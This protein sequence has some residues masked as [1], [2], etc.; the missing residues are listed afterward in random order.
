MRKN[1][2][3]AAMLA[4]S[5]LL[6]GCA[7]LLEREYSTVE[8]HTEQFW[9]S[10]AAGTL[11]AESRQ[12]VVNDLLIL[13]SQHTEKATLRLYNYTDDVNVADML[14][15]A[16][17]EVRRETPM[18]AYAVEYITSS[19][20]AQR[21]YY[22]VELSIGYRRSA[23]QVKAVVNAT[24]AEAVRNLLEGALDAG[25]TELAVRVGYWDES[26]RETVETLISSFTPYSATICRI[27][28]RKPSSTVLFKLMAVSSAVS[29][30]MEIYTSTLPLD[31]A[32]LTACLTASSAKDTLLG[33]FTLQSR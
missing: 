5:V 6:S 33:S 1:L 4:C 14:Q 15:R 19:A 24:S 8:P 21:G 28:P 13:I 3:L 18:G 30:L 31:T 32:V 26:S 12:D 23:E 11:R 25:K 9:E 27:A 7:S 20:T 10:E 16:T 17:D 29:D 22:E 2:M